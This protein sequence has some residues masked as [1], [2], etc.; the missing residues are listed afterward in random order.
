MDTS[1]QTEAQAAPLVQPPFTYDIVGSFLRPA[2]LKQARAD[3]KNGKIDD[4]QLHAIEDECIQKLV[5]KEEAV[6]LKDVT[7]GEFRRSMWHMDFFEGLNGVEKIPSTA[8]SVNFK[9]ANPAGAQIRFDG[10]ISFPDDHPFIEHFRHLKFMSAHL[11]PKFTIPSPSMLHLI[12]CVRGHASY[13][14]IPCYQNNPDALF[15]DIVATYQQAVRLFYHEGCRY[16]QFD[17]TSWGE[18][19]DTS[20]RAAY[21]QAG[22][23]IDA[24]AQKYV[25][26]INQILEVKPN[27]MTITMHICRGNYRSTWFSSG[28]YEPVAPILFAKCNVDGFFL[29]YDTDRAGG[30]EPLRYMNN[31]IVALGLITTKTPELENEDDVIRRIHEAQHYIPLS[32]LRLCPQCGFSSTEEGNNVTEEEQWEKV[33]L[34]KRIADRVWGPQE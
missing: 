22:I 18:F 29:E 24:L 27:D 10:R 1:T 28:G 11:M 26:V 16:L 19:C 13:W 9:G 15:D 23:D 30:F 31:Q 34:V 17:D 25:D 6:G 33:K 21:A 2:Q 4:A 3:Y 32:R 20:K 7:D 12:P 5:Q 8:W 14:P